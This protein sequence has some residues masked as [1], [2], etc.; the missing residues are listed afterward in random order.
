MSGYYYQVR[1]SSEGVLLW[2]G[3]SLDDATRVL[4]SARTYW[5]SPVIVREQW[6]DAGMIGTVFL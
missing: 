1:S 2:D 5:D 3:E 6:D 4:E